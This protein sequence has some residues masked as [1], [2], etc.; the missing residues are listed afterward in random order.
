[1]GAEAGKTTDLLFEPELTGQ[2]IEAGEYVNGAET[3]V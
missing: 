2:S 3:R 1:M